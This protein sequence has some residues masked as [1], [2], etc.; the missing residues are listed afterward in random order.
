MTAASSALT[1][2]H[3]SVERVTVTTA[4]TGDR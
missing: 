2:S 4:G 1:D 3:A